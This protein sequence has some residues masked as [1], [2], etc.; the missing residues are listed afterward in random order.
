MASTSVMETLHIRVPVDIRER[1]ER[2][3]EADDRKATALARRLIVQGL[4]RLT[5]D[6]REPAGAA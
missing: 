3:A 1:L 4:D 2:V 6:S 5:A